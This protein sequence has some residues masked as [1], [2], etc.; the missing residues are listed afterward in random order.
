MIKG[1]IRDKLKRAAVFALCFILAFGINTGG[2]SFSSSDDKHFVRFGMGK[3]EAAYNGEPTYNKTIDGVEY[4]IQEFKSSGTFVV[5]PY[6]TKVDVTV[7]GGG[8]AGNEGEDYGGASDYDQHG[9]GGGGGGYVNNQ[10]NVSVVEGSNISI[11]IGAGGTSGDGG[12]SSFG[13][14][15]TANGGKRSG[16]TSFIGGN[17]GSGGGNGGDQGADSGTGGNQSAYKNPGSGG[18][19]G[20]NGGAGI[21]VGGGGQGTTTYGVNEVLY[22]GGGGGGDWETDSNPPNLGG[23]GGGGR[24][25]R[26]GGYVGSQLVYVAPIAG[27][28]NTGGGGGGGGGHLYHTSVGANGG[29]GIVVI[30]WVA[31]MEPTITVTSPAANSAYSELS[32]YNT[33]AL[34]GTVSDPNTGDIITIKYNI[35]TGATQALSGAVTTSGSY[36]API[37]VGTL[38]EGSHN[39]NV[40]C[41]DNKSAVSSTVTRPFKM[42]RTAPVLGTVTF[43]SATNSVTISGEATDA[44]AGLPTNKYQYTLSTKPVVPWT[45]Q[46]SQ[47]FTGLTSNT[48]YTAKFEARDSVGHISAKQQNIYTKAAVPTAAVSNPK[49]Y[50]LDVS[51][52]DTNPSATLYQIVANTNKYVT[53]EGA[54]TTSPVWITPSGKKITVKGLSPSTTYTFQV[55]AKNGDGVETALSSPVSGTTLIAPPAAP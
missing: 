41:V 5:P 17:G 8:G 54:L 27:A 25:A 3:V 50:T 44:I 26:T 9:G 37:G 15:I 35:D 19:D 36:T 1:K 33:I 30:R 21:G 49:S 16:G 23:A 38:T 48:Q 31:N 29:S 22:A 45:S 52:S 40:W 43:T 34:A 55:K 39:L 53:P 18:S 7:V 10:Y 32:S 42:D 6:V 2:T 24:G 20:S 51:M 47:S 28:V 13:G 46:A 4:V 12:Q 11:I 14:T